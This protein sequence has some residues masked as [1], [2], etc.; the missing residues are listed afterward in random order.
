MTSKEVNSFVRQCRAHQDRT[1]V[2]QDLVAFIKQAQDTKEVDTKEV[3]TKEVDVTLDFS[4]EIKEYLAS[5]T[6]EHKEEEKIDLYA[7]F[8]GHGSGMV[9]VDMAKA[10]L[11]FVIYSMPSFKEKNYGEAIKQGVY[12]LHLQIVDSVRNVRACERYPFGAGTTISLALVTNETI[13]FA[14]GGDSPI[15][16]Q[17]GD[18]YKVIEVSSPAH[19]LNNHVVIDRIIKSEIPLM[20]TSFWGGQV[21]Y[22]D[23]SEK[24]NW[25]RIGNG[26]NTFGGI[27]DAANDAK[28]LNELITFIIEYQSDKAWH[29]ASLVEE[30]SLLEPVKGTRKRKSNCS[31]VKEKEF[32]WNSAMRSKLGINR[33][34]CIGDFGKWLLSRYPALVEKKSESQLCRHFGLFDTNCVPFTTDHPGSDLFE[35][36]LL[37]D[38]PKFMTCDAMMRIPDVVSFKT[39]D[40]KGFALMTDGVHKIGR[41]MDKLNAIFKSTLST[42]STLST[43][44]AD[45][46]NLFQ[47]IYADYSDDRC[48]ILYWS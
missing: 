3:D 21:Y 11:P 30:I 37:Q 2:V 31:T 8:D 34:T 26:L 28:V 35:Y 4:A 23:P 12:K 7:V 22:I 45:A 25:Q 33:Q 13:Y 44:F 32:K 41:S 48:G 29:C 17:V 38:A 46:F 14:W 39:R 5:F 43:S 27:G 47:D 6:E 24:T 16:A 10:L 9:P 19:D 15:I 36:Y 1:L 18:E 42:L 20:R 40:V